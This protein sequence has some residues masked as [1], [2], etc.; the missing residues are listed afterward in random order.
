MKSETPMATQIQAYLLNAGV[1]AAAIIIAEHET[2]HSV[3]Q[4]QQIADRLGAIE[5]R[6]TIPTPDD[7]PSVLH[8]ARGADIALLRHRRDG[9]GARWSR[10]CWWYP[11]WGVNAI[12]LISRGEVVLQ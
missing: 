6:L 4:L 5:Q 3:H 11:W 8:H 7:R 9:G 1:V 2:S 10:R 12:R